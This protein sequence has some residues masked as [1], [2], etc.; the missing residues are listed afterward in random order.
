MRAPANRGIR[1]GV[2]RPSS[3]GDPANHPYPCETP[4]QG[5]LTADSWCHNRRGSVSGAARSDSDASILGA[6]RGVARHDAGWDR[7]RLLRIESFEHARSMLATSELAESHPAAEPDHGPIEQPSARPV[8]LACITTTA[9]RGSHEARVTPRFNP[10][11]SPEIT[12]QHDGRSR[13]RGDPASSSARS[14]GAVA[15]WNR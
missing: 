12:A 8:S 15:R 6:R 10:N 13:R 7:Q 4:A 3:R 11:L 5:D 1:V 9:S 2:A 14:S